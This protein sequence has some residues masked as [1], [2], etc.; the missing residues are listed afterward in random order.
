MASE[1]RIHK[2]STMLEEAAQLLMDPTEAKQLRTMRK[3]KPMRSSSLEHVM[4]GEDLNSGEV[5]GQWT[6]RQL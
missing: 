5:R 4:D 6:D 2:K 3:T 1:S